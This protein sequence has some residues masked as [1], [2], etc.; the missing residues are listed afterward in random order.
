VTAPD[1]TTVVVVQR[2]IR[3][4]PA[5]IFSFF[6]D[7]ARWLR[8]QGVEATIEPVAGGRFRMNVRGDGYASGQFVEVDPPRRIVFSWGWELPGNPV[9]PGSSTVEIDL[10]P[11]G[12]ATVV[13]LTHRGLPLPATRD[14]H[15]EG[16]Q[17]YL[18]RLDAVATGGDP[19]PDPWR[20]P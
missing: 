5:T 17:H 13:R 15:R 9:P 20:V 3:A 4:Q 10:E 12:D 18:E 6:T 1:G 2:R 11:D 19:G 8:W 16:W 7:P 14:H